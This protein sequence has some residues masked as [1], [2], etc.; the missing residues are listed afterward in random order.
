MK[1]SLQP[2]ALFDVSTKKEDINEL[3]PLI[4]NK[5]AQNKMYSQ[6]TCSTEFKGKLPYKLSSSKEIYIGLVYKKGQAS[7]F[8]DRLHQEKKH[9]KLMIEYYIET[10][11]KPK[12]V[13]QSIHRRIGQKKNP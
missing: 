11:A 9:V 6:N 12:K 5:D 7:T 8:K 4:Y 2:C 10:K 13:Q 1:R 3:W